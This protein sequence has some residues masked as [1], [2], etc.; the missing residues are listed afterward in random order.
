MKNLHM[1][2]VCGHAYGIFQ[3]ALGFTYYLSKLNF[4]GKKMA[5]QIPANKKPRRRAHPTTLE[6]IKATKIKKKKKTNKQ[7]NKTKHKQTNKQNKAQTNKQTKQSTN[8][9]T[10]K[11][12]GCNR[13]RLSFFADLS[14]KN[15]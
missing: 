6:L 7:T 12:Y 13:P 15:W 3:W 5:G 10:N 2:W 8:K 1:L 4:G 14:D 11:L 9:Q